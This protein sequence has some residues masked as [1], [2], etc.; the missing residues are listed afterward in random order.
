MVEGDD[1]FGNGVNVSARME[2]VAEAGGICISGNVYEHVGG[3]LNLI[4]ENLGEQTVKNLD[5]PVLCYR[6][7]LEPAAER[8]QIAPADSSL[9]L[10][11]KPSIAVLPFTNLSGE[12]DQEPF[13]DGMTDDLITD[14]SK[15]SGLL[16]IASNT[17]FTYKGKRID[18]R[19]AARELGVR[20]VVEGSV[21]KAGQQVRINAQL[22]DSTTGGHLWADRYDGDLTDAFALQDQVCRQ[23]VDA[24][25]VRLDQGE[26]QRLQHV[27]TRNVEAYELY[28][29]AKS[30]PYPPVKER[31]ARARDIY[32]RVID[33][34]PSFA[35]GYA[36]LAAMLAWGTH[37]G[38]WDDPETEIERAV[39]LA[40]KGIEADD[41][42][43]WTYTALGLAH[44]A[45]G[46]FDEA[47]AAAEEGE[48]RQPG[49]ADTLAY[50]AY[51]QIWIGRAQEALE[52][53]ERAIV[54]NP[55]LNVPYYYWMMLAQ[56]TLGNYDRAADAFQA[57]VDRGG[58]TALPGNCVAAAANAAAGR[59]DEAARLV[60]LVLEERPD[61]KIGS[62][63]RPYWWKEPANNERFFAALREAGFS[64]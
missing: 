14:L 54:L 51:C 42:F 48:R 23:V 7:L 55:H 56:F 36:G 13:A 62:W 64:E 31:I 2:G 35:G 18:V 27:H 40:R 25:S 38:H 12:T 1:L 37:F 34:D 19:D 63:H 22:I 11:N 57:N 46:E 50:H 9:A 58:P 32:Q 39:V 49:D 41:T 28:V 15:I 26:H 3:A 61:Y 60:R 5:R 47:V 52:R 16:V 10:S 17:S 21:R 6:V 44:L 59:M 4:F 24:L 8:S 45:R 33:I 30:I 29:R 43:G 53:L 20:Y